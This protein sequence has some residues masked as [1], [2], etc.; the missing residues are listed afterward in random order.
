[1]R[2]PRSRLALAS[3]LSACS[4]VAAVVLT[5]WATPSQAQS[6]PD[7]QVDALEAVAGKHA[8][9]RRSGAKGICASGHFEGNAVGRSLSSA[10]VFSGQKV[11][12]LARFSVGGGNPKASDKSKTV[13]GLALQFTLPKGEQWMMASISAPMFF[14]ARPEQLVPFLMARVNDPATGKPDPAKVKAFSDANPETTRQ[15]AYLAKTLVPASYASTPYWGVNAFELVNAKGRGQ[16]VRWVFVPTGGTLGL[17]DEQL[18]TLP[19]AFLFDELR[20]R[21]A[22]HPVTFDF[23]LQLA[24]A[25]DPLTD[26]TQVWPDSRVLLPAG[27]LTIDKVEADMGG[28]CDKIT[29][30]PLVLPKGIKASADPVLAARPAA[31]GVSLGRRLGESAAMMK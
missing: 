12:V 5:A 14:I 9:M 8:G 25:G 13:R 23:K 10:S 31:Y 21:V 4:A 18:K 6:T 3:S 26:P 24:E 28:A 22:E 30:N 2:S 20:K 11:P 27:T 15:G 19:D 7:A 16:F 17:T 1:M 29:F